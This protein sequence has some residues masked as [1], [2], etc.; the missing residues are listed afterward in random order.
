MRGCVLYLAKKRRCCRYPAGVITSVDG[1]AV[2][3]LDGAGPAVCSRVL[4]WARG[5]VLP[6]M[7][8]RRSVAR[9]SRNSD[10]EC[11]ADNNSSKKSVGI[12]NGIDCRLH[13]DFKFATP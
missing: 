4:C 13:A 9:I 10:C 11:W 6:Y 5:G 12:E 1:F 3:V 2:L 8:W 7:Y